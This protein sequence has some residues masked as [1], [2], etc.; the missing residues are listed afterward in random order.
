MKPFDVL[1]YGLVIFGWSTSWLPLKWQLGVVAPEVSLM[2]RFL[3]AS[4][5]MF[6]VTAISRQPLTIPWRQH[7]RLMGL[8]VFLFSCNF[9]LFYYG[10]L[11]ATSGLLAVVFSTASLI[12]MF[13]MGVFFRQKPK[14][15][16][17]IAGI[18]GF[19]GVGLMF[20]P[21]LSGGTTSF[22]SLL[23]CLSGTTVFCCGNLISSRAQHAGLPV[24]AANSWGMMYGAIFLAMLSLVRGHGFTVEWT[25]PYLGGMV[26]LAVVSSVL[27][28]TAYLALL[29]RIG[30]SR[31]GYA[32]VIFPVGALVISTF[33][34]NYQWTGLAILGLG[35]VVIGNVIMARLR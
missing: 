15:M 21:E 17:I 18:F 16:M 28:F 20:A 29:G 14:A 25:A 35:F 9:T 22:A 27:A 3:L 26:W 24:M 13:L 7:W 5:L 2:W 32:T 19:S 30:P 12:N 34:E 8:G 10:G 23:L 33:V 6:L 31:A 4:A 1:L 11:E